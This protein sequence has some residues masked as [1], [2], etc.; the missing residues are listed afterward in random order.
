MSEEERSRS[1]PTRPLVLPDT[2]TGDDN[3]DHWISHFESVSAVNQWTD[4]DKL[5][6]LRVRLTGKAHV[7]LDQLPHEIQQ[8][9]SNVKKALRERFEPESKR[10]LYKAEFETRRKK[11]SE[12]WADFADDLRRLTDKAFPNLQCEAREELA[13]SRYLDQLGPPQISFAVKQRRPRNLPEAVSSTIELESYLPREQSVRAVSDDTCNTATGPANPLTPQI[14]PVQAISDQPLLQQLLDRIEKLEMTRPRP[15]Q[16][17]SRTE[18]RRLRQQGGVPKEIT[19]YRCGRPGHYAR[20]CAA[21]RSYRQQEQRDQD[22][23]TEQPLHNAQPF[24]INNVSSYLLP[25]CMNNVPVSFLVDTGAGVSLLQ[26]AV[27]DRIKP[28]NHNLKTVTVHRLVGVDG[29]P[30]SIRGSTVVQFSVYGIKFQHEFVIADQITSEAILGLDFLEPNKC[31]LD[32]ANEKMYIQDKPV[33]LQ[34]LQSFNVSKCVKVT[35]V[36]TVTVPPCS[37]M[38]LIAHVNVPQDGTWLIEGTG[39]PVLVARAIV[40][41]EQCNVVVRVVNTELTPVK[42]YK[43]MKIATAEPIEDHIICEVSKGKSLQA[44]PEGSSDIILA[45]PLP[46]DITSDQKEKFLALMAHYSDILA[47]GPDKLGRTGVLQHHIN[48]D[49]AT[50]IRQ[51]AR[52]VPLPRRETVHNLLQDMLSKN[53]ISPS[54]SPWASPIVLVAKKDGST[55][56]CVDYRKLN[57]VTRKDAYPLPRVDDSL[58]TLTG[59]KWFS[60]LDLRSGYWQVEVCPEHRAKTAFTTQEGLFEFNVMPFGLCNAPATFQRLMDSVLAGL[61]WSACLVYIDDI[62]IM[63][64]SFD[65]H[66]R[67]LQTV[68]ERLRQ[69]GLKLHPG[70]CQFLQQKV[71]FLGHV[72]SADGL[73]PDPNK[74]SK[75]K[76]W[77]TP[78]T[79]QEV[80]Q[81][82]GLANYY[83]RFIHNFA[84]IAKPLHHLTE[85]HTKFQWNH[86]CQNA[87]TALKT[88]LTSAPILALPD[89]SRPFVLD[90]D[91]SDAGIGAVLSQIHQDGREY[92]IAYASRTLNRAERN[93]CATRKELLAVVTFMKHF[94]QYLVGHNFTVRTDH[95]ALTWLQNFK[96]PEGQLARWLETLQDYQFDIVHRPGCRHNN[97]DALSR[98]PCSQCG[99]ESHSPKS[100]ELISVI[101]ASNYIG[102]Y[103]TKDLRDSQLNDPCIGELLLAHESNQKP[104]QDHAKGKD[105]EYRRLLQQWEQLTIKDDILWRYFAHPNHDGGHLQLVVPRN[106]RDEILKECHEGMSGGHLGQEKTLHRVKERFYWP[107]HY[108]DVCNWCLTCKACATRKTPAP[109]QRAP[110]GTV[111]AG[112]PT[113][114]MAVDLVGPLPESTSGNSYI[115]VVGDYFTKWMEAL[116]VPNQEAVTVAEKLVNEVFFRYSIPE[117]LHSDQGAQFESQLM[118]EVCK[119]L[120]INKTRTT[121]YHPQCDGLVE[122]FNRTLLNMLASCANDHPFDWEKHIRK[123][124]MAYNSSIHSSTGHTPFYLMFGRQARLP[125]D[126]MYGTGEHDEAQSPCEYATTLKQRLTSAFTL[127]RERLKTTHQRQKALYDQKIHGNPYHQGTLV[128]LHVPFTGRRGSRKLYHPW[129]GPYKVVKQLS[130]A[131]YRIQKLHGRRQR[132]VVHFDHLKP[133]PANMR[134]DYDSDNSRTATDI[135]STTEHDTTQSRTPANI[136]QDLDLVEE[137]DNWEYSNPA[138]SL[139]VAAPNTRYPSRDRRPP[140]RY[141]SFVRI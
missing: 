3:F 128:W 20:G 114:V 124:C 60:T 112:Y 133:C 69:A 47:D 129:T 11:A 87:F 102:G 37:E 26:G 74:T 91:A 18:P 101:S 107:G 111:K 81:F 63:G 56:F 38:E 96:S 120:H 40:A 36:E 113:Q 138:I 30:I 2:F 77:P 117:Q 141:D 88:C 130:E 68:F 51:Q 54:Q 110:L 4:A 86:D 97:A 64:K 41:P 126:I 66:M 12:T 34:P 132:K 122:R 49:N 53:I 8:S 31:V 16:Q 24:S 127:V 27:W 5:L 17:S 134:L 119:L 7:A 103:S 10:M 21:G 82:L 105:L 137:D 25:C 90:T 123:V 99:R 109:T 14:T 19:C 100:A 59:S 35:V 6:W 72:V 23:K 71:Y 42:L 65:D 94:R 92:V 80:Q 32:L 115:L 108:N 13:L 9:Y 57:T 50:P 136:G 118:G 43:N 29:V 58:D 131:T 73:L 121:P 84:V 79:V 61:Q 89:W 85:K 140:S 67:N 39:C 125:V 45:N 83:R 116:P 78:G 106:L 62:I 55:R 52:R 75:V 93:Y 95:A 46:D 139:P 22:F 15:T 33:P 104:S 28:Q 48:T 70:K 135:T 76:D 98:L 1:Q 44:Q